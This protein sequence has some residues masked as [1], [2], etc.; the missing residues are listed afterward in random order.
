MALINNPIPPRAYE[1]IR[2]R[3]GNIL[4]VELMN[5]EAITYD[6]LFDVPVFVQRS[7]PVNQDE[8]KIIN[9]SFD[10]GR[11]SGQTVISA[12]GD[13]TFY[14]DVIVTGQ[15]TQTGRGDVLTN[16]NAQKLAGVCCGILEDPQYITLGFNRPFIGRSHVTD[17]APGMIERGEA[18]E[19]SVVRITLN[20]FCLQNEPAITGIPLSQNLTT[21]HLG[22]TN[23][24]FQYITT[25]Q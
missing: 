8:P 12:N 19:L 17:I 22:E 25:G 5:Q 7:K 16:Y 2:D 21:V 13:F 15:S 24:G 23:L 10:T 3:I 4:A 6:E 9:V 11:F 14:I 18:T 20:V 1:L